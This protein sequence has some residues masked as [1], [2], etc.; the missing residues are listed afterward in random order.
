MFE[1]ERYELNEGP[2]YRFDS[3]R[4]DFFKLLGAG[5]VVVAALDA[6]ESGGGRGGRNA[7][8]KE[9]AA[10][11][12]IGEDGRITF[13][14]GKAEVGQ[15]TR[16]ALTQAVAEELHAPVESIHLLMSDTDV[17]PFDMGTF[18]SLSTPVMAPLLR[19]AAITAREWLIDLAAERLGRD[20]AAVTIEQALA[21]PDLAKGKTL[22]RTVSDQPISKPKCES[23]PKIDGRAFVTGA[24]KYV[25]DMKLPGMLNGK[26]LRA[27]AYKAKLASV[28]GDVIRDGDFAGVA[29]ARPSLDGVKA[30]WKFGPH[31]SSKE[32]FPLLRKT[33]ATQPK[34]PLDFSGAA[35][36][37]DA[38][39]EIAYIAH[40]P[41]EPRAA[42]AE[43]RG[44]KL[45]VW[46]GTQRPFGVRDELAEAFGIPQSK[47]RVLVPDTG[48][49]Y[50]GK[51]T[52]ETA[53]EAARLAKAAGKPVKV[54][55]TRQE[56][57]TWAY[58][59]PAGVIDV[60]GALDA[61]GC[62]TGWEMHN[63]NS[64]GSALDTPYAVGTKQT[65]FHES[66]APLRQGSYRGLAATANNFARES[67]MDDL[68]RLAKID[69]LAF[70]LKN[71]TDDRMKGVLDAAAG[72]FGWAGK[73]GTGIACGF[74]KRGYVATCAE[75][76]VDAGVIR[77]V[78]AVTAFDCGA[79]VNPTHLKNQIEGSVV[80]GIGGALFEHGEFDGGRLLTDRLSRYRVPRFSDVPAMETVLVD[81]KDIPSAGAGETP[82]I[83][84]APAIANALASLTG[85]RRRHMP[86]NRG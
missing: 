66:D 75:I 15:N 14:T 11:L 23:V 9:L 63:Y 33:A 34:P 39:Y 69:P 19:R 76:A 80:M 24:H 74:E 7:Q 13:F 51:H 18:G 77:V 46:S 47:V 6:Q 25:S 64:G 85:E 5:L 43:W 3:N 65:Q 60:R 84:I 82:I 12:H 32:L 2:A 35:Q 53:I 67:H 42:V 68:A 16:T 4:R 52:G 38:T 27:P 17:V 20:P 28:S 36:H 62:L 79:V 83:G 81:R 54:V 56:E 26:V 71:L 49:G 48:S 45:T 58:W 29:A 40:I 78:R 73:P 31:P 8:P 41:L 59:R 30:E 21:I 37:L 1:V 22:T 86:L 10:W 72:K 44:D 61:E 55:W 70:R 50:G 57:F